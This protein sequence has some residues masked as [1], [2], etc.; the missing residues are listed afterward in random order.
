METKE[1]LEALK[2]V[3]ADTLT[4]IDKRLEEQNRQIDKRLEEQNRQIDKKLDEQS[5]RLLNEF[6]VVIEDKVS[7]EIRLIAE[8]HM[9]ILE[10][11]PDVDKQE[12]LKSRVKVLEQVVLD[13]RIELDELKK[14]Q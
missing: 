9:N 2:E 6:N 5:Q 13:M 10:R 7:H 4:Q 1:I 14:A 3:Q 12:Q 8:G 11:L